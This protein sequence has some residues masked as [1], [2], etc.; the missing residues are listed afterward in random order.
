MKGLSAL[1]STA[2]GRLEQLKKSLE[3]VLGDNLVSLIVHGS[4]VR[5]G[6][7]DG[8]SDVD[9]VLIIRNDARDKL[10]A[11][12]DALQLARFSARIETMILTSDEVGRAADAFPLLYDDIQRCHVVLSG[13]DPFDGLEIAERHRRLRIEQELREG[14]IRMR[15]ALVDSM[16]QQKLLAGAVVRKVRQLRGPMLALLAL[17]GIECPDTLEDVYAVA[18]KTWDVDHKPLLN[19]NNA[20]Y[21]AHDALS[22]LLTKA[23]DDVD[24]RPEG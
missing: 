5:G 11:A 17:K 14:Q 18:G 9:V 24:R 2:Q 7:R 12:S 4:A 8:Q 13:T 10:M 16:G 6:F 3:E 22:A 21:A 19:A 20:P 23:V 1:P 15:R